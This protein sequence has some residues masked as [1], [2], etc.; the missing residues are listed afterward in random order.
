MK[1]KIGRRTL[2]VRG[3]ALA[4]GAAA[5]SLIDTSTAQAS[6]GSSAALIVAADGNAV[7]ETTAGK[8]RGFT[9]NGI[10][11]F[12]GIPF[13]ASTEG[14]GRFV[15]PAKP[16]PWTG[17]RSSMYY[18]PTCPQ[19]PRNGWHKDENAFLF[20]WDDG[21][22]GEDCLRINLWTPGL[23]DGKKRPVMVWLHG[24]GWAAGSG[25]EQPAYNGEN[26]SKRGD[27]VVLSLNH[28]LNIL[29]YLN[30]AAYGEK[31]A[32]SANSGVLDI[33]VALEWVRDNITAFGGDPG[34]VTIFGQSGGGAKVSTL[35]AMPMAK[36]LF[37][38]AVVQS[39]STLRL[40]DA[41]S[42][43]KLAAAV[44]AELGLSKATIDKIQT[45]DYTRLLE[46]GE[47]A[48]R[49]LQPNPPLAGPGV[50]AARGAAQRLGF[51][52][53]VD[54]KYVT[55][56]PFDPDAPGESGSVPMLIGTVMN[57]QSPSMFDA[58]LES[59]TED[60]MRTRAERRYGAQT[61]MVVDAY[62]KAYPRVKPVELLSRMSSVRTS[63]V[64]Q[65][66]RKAAQGAAPA[67][68]YLFAW[69]TPVLN[70]RPRAFHC[71]EIPFVF[72]NT[73]VSAFSTG[74]TAE[75]RELAAKVSDA[76]INF[77][78]HGDPN[79]SG[80]PKWPVF[81]AE[82]GP[83]MIFDKTSEVKN[84]PDREL[85]RAVAAALG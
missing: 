22:P 13:A 65:A 8:V 28:R 32:D 47:S 21:Q 69:Q 50:P 2:L 18:G 3:A 7:V 30:L 75:A 9:R 80:L 31:Y 82:S 26:L 70:G 57:E 62:R 44:V 38:K 85:R 63:A 17:V 25:Q 59:M 79:H 35:A 45:V 77:A 23:G 1:S 14:A 49:N 39:G 19:A 61:K 29:G 60:E 27:V 52:P 73:D 40:G 74:G 48:I 36:S 11:T 46:A 12:K 67:Y 37:H 64:M 78:R 5:T 84:D 83:V 10:Q 56:H 24:G 43:A 55:R 68:M 66:E 51:N 72:N 20:Q 76:W 33:V 58:A 53:V 81:N 6:T 42:A 16:K 15:A 4:G 41:E 54:G 71:S 34:N